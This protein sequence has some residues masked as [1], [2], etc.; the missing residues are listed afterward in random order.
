MSKITPEEYELAVLEKLR[1]DFAPVAVRVWGTEHGNKH[2]VRGRHSLVDRQLDAAAYRLGEERPFL[3]A[4]AKRHR[5]K[6]DV[7]EVEAFLGMVDDVGAGI[8]LLVA[9]RGF[10]DAAERRAAAASMSVL[11]MTVEQALTYRWLPVARKVYPYDWVFHERIAHA[12]RLLHETAPPFRI[13]DA[14]EPVA[15]EEWD[16]LVSHALTQHR[17][18]ACE[19]LLAIARH[20][21]DSSWRFNA[22]QR[23]IGGDF[24]ASEVR[25]ELLESERD[26]DTVELLSG[27]WA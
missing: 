16:A 13:A 23:L 25:R 22:V 3:V 11:V 15:F 1:L 14:L 2:H 17:D 20:H 5:R 12:L 8:G 4:D 19:L 7:K 24:L 21:H 9:P 26:P 27:G 18:Q 10:T 6:L